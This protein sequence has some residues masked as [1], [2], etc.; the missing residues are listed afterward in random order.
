[1]IYFYSPTEKKKNGGYNRILY[2]F[3]VRQR[4]YSSSFSVLQKYAAI[5]VFASAETG[6]DAPIRYSRCPSQAIRD[7]TF[8][9]NL[10]VFH[11]CCDKRND[12]YGTCTTPDNVGSTTTERDVTRR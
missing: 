10:T 4:H 9:R 12:W 1:M 7:V 8:G 6:S 5:A 11:E 2:D 3:V